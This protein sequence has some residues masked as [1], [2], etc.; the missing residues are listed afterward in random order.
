MSPSRRGLLHDTF[1]GLTEL[2]ARIQDHARR[3]DHLQ[4]EIARLERQGTTAARPH[5]R[6]GRYLYLVHPQRDG[7]RRRE[8]VGVNPTRVARALYQVERWERVQALRAELAELE[9]QLRH[10]A[11]RL[12]G[13]SA[14][15]W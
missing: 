14:S 8:Y 13:T 6:A 12:P 2:Q 11:A 4:R 3:S 5:W 9:D 15:I 7:R 1:Q 10:I